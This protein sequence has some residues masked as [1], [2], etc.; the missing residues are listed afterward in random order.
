MAQFMLY[1]DPM[2]FSLLPSRQVPLPW[3]ISTTSARAEPVKLTTKAQQNESTDTPATPP[4][5]HTGARVQHLHSIT[6]APISPLQP[7]TSP[8]SLEA[9]LRAEQILR[10]EM[11]MC[12]IKGQLQDGVDISIAQ[13][14]SYRRFSR[15]VNVCTQHPVH[16]TF[17]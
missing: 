1:Y 12:D 5:I 7:S 10:G 11:C 16:E 8:L 3:S 17:D 13:G 15:T 9:L 2:E 14:H 6:A 4:C